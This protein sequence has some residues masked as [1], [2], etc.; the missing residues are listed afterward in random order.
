MATETRPLEMPEPDDQNAR[1]G[2]PDELKKVGVQLPETPTGARVSIDKVNDVRED[3][4]DDV[5]KPP[6]EHH[7]DKP[8]TLTGQ[9]ERTAEAS[10]EVANEEA[11]DSMKED[12]SKDIKV[13]A[14]DPKLVEGEGKIDLDTRQ[15]MGF[16]TAT[17]P[18]REALSKNLTLR[19]LYE[20][21]TRKIY[22]DTNG[23]DQTADRAPRLTRTFV[24]YISAVD[25]RLS[26]LESKIL[27]LGK[28]KSAGEKKDDINKSDKSGDGSPPAPKTK[29][30]RT[31]S[32][33][34]D[35]SFLSRSESDADP[36]VRLWVLYMSATESA[37]P[38]GSDPN[39]ATIEVTEIGIR[40]PA[41]FSFFE[42]NLDY[43]LQKDGIIH[44]RWPFRILLRMSDKIY[45]HTKW[46]ENLYGYDCTGLLGGFSH[47][48]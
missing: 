38:R 47:W 31:F 18:F 26:K 40:S 21:Y 1:E 25:D 30:K 14:D 23:L 24:E 12:P 4:G 10:K 48:N 33:E 41:I 3:A 19:Q 16:P 34:D 44:M 8:S 22:N 43:T 27:E 15:E 39:P 5:T 29:F 20:L 37:V 32:R 7:N 42:E 35:S 45:Q 2:H 11:R 13:D 28:D 6:S 9:P 17:P 46:L 36:T